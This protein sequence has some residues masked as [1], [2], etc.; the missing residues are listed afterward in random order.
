[1]FTSHVFLALEHDECVAAMRLALLVT[2][3][4]CMGISDY[5]DLKEISFACMFGDYFGRTY[6]F[7][8]PEAPKLPLEILLIGFVAETRDDQRLESVASDVWIILR[9]V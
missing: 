1:M 7:N 9:M 6:T 4:I 3:L 2:L 5:P 8:R